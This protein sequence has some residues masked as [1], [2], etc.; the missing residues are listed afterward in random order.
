MFPFWLASMK[1]HKDLANKATVEP[2]KTRDCMV[3]GVTVSEDI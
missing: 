3:N 2:Q 1:L